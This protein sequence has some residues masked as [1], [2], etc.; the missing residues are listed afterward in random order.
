[1]L[2]REASSERVRRL[3]CCWPKRLR[4]Y[5]SPH[6]N[7]TCSIYG[8]AVTPHKQYSF[9]PPPNSKGLDVARNPFDLGALSLW[10]PWQPPGQI[11]SCAWAQRCFEKKRLVAVCLAKQIAQR[12]Y[13]PRALP[14]NRQCIDCETDCATRLHKA[15]RLRRDSSKLHSGTIT[16]NLPASKLRANASC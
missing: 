3:P 8:R 12:F 14:G 10:V 9:H 16:I 2:N 4:R 13:R 6:Q 11:E 15:E 7:I 5:L 1:M